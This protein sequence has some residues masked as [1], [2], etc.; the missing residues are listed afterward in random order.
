MA[1]LDSVIGLSMH[2]GPGH[3]NDPDMLE[4]SSNPFPPAE[5]IPPSTLPPTVCASTSECLA[6][7]GKSLVNGSRGCL[8]CC[9]AD[10]WHGSH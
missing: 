10:A 5:L 2:A 1:N 7:R 3:W 4:V 8:Q 9:C 6:V